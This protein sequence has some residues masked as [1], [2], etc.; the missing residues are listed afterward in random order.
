MA[1]SLRYNHIAI[2]FRGGDILLGMV[3]GILSIN[4]FEMN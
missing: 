3:A 1:I 4:R 2:N